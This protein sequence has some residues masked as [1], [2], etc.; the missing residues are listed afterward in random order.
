MVGSAN[1]GPKILV[2]YDIG[3][4]ISVQRLHNVFYDCVFDRGEYPA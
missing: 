1:K 2:R 4:F 3:E